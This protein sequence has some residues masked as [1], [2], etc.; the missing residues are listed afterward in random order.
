MEKADYP[1]VIY[2]KQLNVENMNTLH[3]SDLKWPLLYTHLILPF[4]SC[5]AKHHCH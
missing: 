5:T 3:N 1:E 2:E 4:G